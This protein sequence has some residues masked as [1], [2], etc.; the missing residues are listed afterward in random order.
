MAMDQKK[1][2]NVYY[3][4]TLFNVEEYLKDLGPIAMAKY[5]IPAAQEDFNMVEYHRDISMMLCTI[6]N[7]IYHCMPVRDDI[8]GPIFADPPTCLPQEFLK[9]RNQDFTI[10]VNT[11]MTRLSVAKSLEEIALLE[12]EFSLLQTS[13]RV[14]EVVLKTAIYALLEDATFKA[15]WSIPSLAGRFD[16]LKDCAE[17]LASSFPHTAT[18]ESDFSIVQLET[19]GGRGQLEHYSL[20]GIVQCNEHER[21][22]AVVYGEK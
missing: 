22:K 2:A 4:I 9:L 7:G 12:D 10:L 6:V 14:T 16:H 11:H 1:T 15:S 5:D 17:G 20:E 13:Y 21:L 19:D 3:S 18:I 8:N